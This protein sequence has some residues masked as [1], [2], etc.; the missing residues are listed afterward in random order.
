VRALEIPT[1]RWTT[2]QAKEA[3]IPPPENMPATVQ[4]R[5]W[6]SPIW[7][8]PTAEAKAAA[9]AGGVSIADLKAGGAAQLDQT[10][11]SALIVGKDTWLRNSVTGGLFRIVWQ[12]NGQRTFWNVNPRDPQPQHFGFDVEES[13][14]GLT[15]AYDVTEGKVV[16]D[17]GNTPLT[18]TAYKSGDKTLLARSDE[19]GFANY[20]VVA[21]P[22]ALIDLGSVKR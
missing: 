9:T 21:V 14:L 3:G 10:A 5:A 1:P 18:W 6:T 22:D 15:A 12:A 16:E 19:F 13:Y 7:Y 4:E 8:T 11:L 2:I 20:E 17:F